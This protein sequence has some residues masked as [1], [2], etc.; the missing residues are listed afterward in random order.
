MAMYFFFFFPFYCF[1]GFSIHSRIT[2]HSEKPATAILHWNWKTEPMHYID[3]TETMTGT[4]LQLIMLYFIISTGE[5][6]ILCCP[7]MENAHSYLLTHTLTF[8]TFSF[9][10]HSLDVVYITRH[11]IRTWPWNAKI[12][13]LKYKGILID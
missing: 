7:N 13:D 3:G 4:L 5:Y 1:I 6:D 11:I 9:C 10:D 8:R 2:L 12:K